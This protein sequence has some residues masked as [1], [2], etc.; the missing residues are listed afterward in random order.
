M[1]DHNDLYSLYWFYEY[2]VAAL[3]EK[4]TTR[5]CGFKG[6]YIGFSVPDKYV[7]DCTYQLFTNE[8]K[9]IWHRFI[10]GY[11]LDYNEA[12]RD[13]GH[14]GVINAAGIEQYRDFESM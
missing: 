10:V 4:R 12:Y 5:S 13:L 9:C 1:L 6:D 11:C 3:V 8:G 7:C 2:R 14:I